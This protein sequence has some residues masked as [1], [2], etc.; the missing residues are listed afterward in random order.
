[1][2]EDFEKKEHQLFGKDGLEENG[3]R[4]AKLE[5][6]IGIHD[7]TSSRRPK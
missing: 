1:M 5:K 3:D 6:T 4:V 7:L 2:T